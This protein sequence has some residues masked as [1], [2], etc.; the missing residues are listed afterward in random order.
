MH[1]QPPC[2][3][4]SFSKAD[5][6]ESDNSLTVKCLFELIYALS[7]LFDEVVEQLT[8]WKSGEGRGLK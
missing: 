5:Q 3:T 7:A 1:Q 2:L 8:C 6:V 4:A